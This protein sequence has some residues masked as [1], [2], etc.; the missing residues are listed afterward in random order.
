MRIAVLA[1]G[2]G[3]RDGA[4]LFDMK[5]QGR[6]SSASWIAEPRMRPAKRVLTGLRA[7]LDRLPRMLGSTRIGGSSMFVRRFAPQDDKLHL[8]RVRDEHLEGL[9]AHLGALLGRAHR[10]AATKIPHSPWSKSDRLGIVER[11]IVI[12][13]VHEGAYLAMC[14]RA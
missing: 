12:A 9:A 5:E 13:G 2:R 3:G 7:S 8:E 14:R 1:R 6:P 11:A 10:R 4:W